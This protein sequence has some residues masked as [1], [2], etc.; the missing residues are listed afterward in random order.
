MTFRISHVAIKFRKLKV[1]WKKVIKMKCTIRIKYNGEFRVFCTHKLI[2]FSPTYSDIYF[3]QVSCHGTQ[4]NPA[5]GTRNLFLAKHP[6]ASGIF[7]EGGEFI[8]TQISNNKRITRTTKSH[9]FSLFGPNIELFFSL[10]FH[11]YHHQ[12][13]HNT[14]LILYYV[15]MHSYLCILFGSGRRH[16]NNNIII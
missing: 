10:L 14:L 15:V 9:Y 6:T 8:A 11:H 13:S 2:Q 16:N 1:R 7:S 3:N 12:R 4:K 5:D